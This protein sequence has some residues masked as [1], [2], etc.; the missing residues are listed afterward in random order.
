[1]NRTEQEAEI[2]QANYERK[3]QEL[4]G[5][6]TGYQKKFMEVR[7]AAFSKKYRFISFFGFFLQYETMLRQKKQNETKLNTQLQAAMNDLQRL[8]T[9]SAA[10][11]SLVLKNRA[12]H[13]A[14]SEG[15]RE[16]SQECSKRRH[17]RNQDLAET[18]QSKNL[19]DLK[20]TATQRDSGTIQLLR[21]KK[22]RY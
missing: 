11:P 17:S 19:G 5:E 6:I 3:V 13:R 20:I 4:S 15:S 7:V 16:E 10:G 18:R 22:A 21:G 2:V 14:T 9:V 8:R 1:L 12:G